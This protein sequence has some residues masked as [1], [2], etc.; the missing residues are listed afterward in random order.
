MPVLPWIEPDMQT[1]RASLRGPARVRLACERVSGSLLR[2]TPTPLRQRPNPMTTNQTLADEIEGLAEKATRYFIDCEFDGHNG[3]LLSIALVSET[4]ESVHIETDV[5]ASDP[6]VLANVI[7]LMGKH[8]ATN[9]TRVSLNA[10][11]GIIR[12]FLGDAQAP[13]IVADSPVDIARFCQAISTGAEG[14]WACTDYPRMTFEVHN[15]DCYPTDLPGAVQHNAWWDAM[16]LQHKLT[17][18]RAQPSPA[19]EPDLYQYHPKTHTNVKHFGVAPLN[20]LEKEIGWTQTPFWK[21]PP[22]EPDRERVVWQPIETAPK[23][24][25]EFVMLDAAIKCVAVGRW[26]SDVAWRNAALRAGEPLIYPSWF[27]L[28]APT[29]WMPLPAPPEADAALAATETKG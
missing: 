23:D 6:W 11:G 16:A 12:E 9:C 8:D 15:V 26:D 4:G 20:D 3:P 19:P 18:L 25:T 22:K 5:Q 29:H 17:A 27:P 24:G 2:R 13:C 7:P 1:P 28:C 14:E 10:V 21:H